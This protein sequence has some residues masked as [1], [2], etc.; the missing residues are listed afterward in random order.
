MHCPVRFP[1][2]LEAPG[3]ERSPIEQLVQDGLGKPARLDSLRGS[4]PSSS[5]PLRA[6]RIRHE[7]AALRVRNE[8]RRLS[9]AAIQ[10]ES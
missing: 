1:D 5:V 3:V 7:V 9:R 2:P 6:Y 8:N 10:G 4:T